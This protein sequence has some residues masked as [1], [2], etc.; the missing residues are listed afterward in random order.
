MQSQPSV[1]AAFEMMETLPNGFP[2]LHLEATVT[3][4]PQLALPG[5]LSC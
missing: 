4:Q 2:T 3:A 1:T 5:V